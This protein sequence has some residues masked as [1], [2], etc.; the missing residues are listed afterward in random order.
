MVFGFQELVGR[1]PATPPDLAQVTH[2]GLTCVGAKLDKAVFGTVALRGG[3]RVY[4]GM[5]WGW[6]RAARFILPPR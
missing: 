1:E 3:D 2:L 6:S 4:G 5:G